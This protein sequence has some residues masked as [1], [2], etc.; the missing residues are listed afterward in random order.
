MRNGIELTQQIQSEGERGPACGGAGC[1]FVVAML[2]GVPFAA[3][4][5]WMAWDILRATTTSLAMQSWV[6]SPARITRSELVCH[7][8]GDGTTYEAVAEYEYAFQGRPYRGSRV[9][10][11][12]KSDS[13]G[14][15]QERMYRKL[16]AHQANGRPFPSYINPDRP[17]ESILDR[18][19]RWE[20]IAF[21][22]IFVIAFGGIGSVCLIGG[23]IAACE[24]RSKARAAAIHPDKPWMWRPDWAAGHVENAGDS[25]LWWLTGAAL[26]ANLFT[27][28]LWWLLPP[29]IA[30]GNYAAMVAAILPAIGIYTAIA[31][32]RRVA[33]H[34]KFGRCVFRMEKTPGAIGGELV[35]SIETVVALTGTA[36]VRVS[37]CC[38]RQIS[39]GD[40]SFSKK[41]EIWR[42]EQM[43]AAM[44][45]AAG[46]SSIPVRFAIPQD[47]PP[48]EEL[49]STTSEWRLKAAADSPGIGFRA[50]FVVPVYR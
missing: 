37:L 11:H 8:D 3:F 30:D 41:N 15:Y 19:L 45:I 24:A 27:A 16:Q 17:E 32:V 46:G 18:D 39:E 21:E 25:F 49:E 42:S 22:D 26:V 12:W 47:C 4:G 28:P 31:A 43:V 34:L 1:G 6:E 50:E 35:G 44:P 5:T 10:L 20:I 48:S 7:N 9:G 13:V 36:D 14:G 29:E 33:R 23:Y 40:G 38:Q 2:F